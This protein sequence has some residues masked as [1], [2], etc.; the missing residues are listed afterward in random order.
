M[1]TLRHAQARC[2][3]KKLLPHQGR[4]QAFNIRK[5]RNPVHH[6]GRAP[7]ARVTAHHL[8]YIIEKPDRFTFKINT[9][10][11]PP[12]VDQKP[13]LWAH[14]MKNRT[15]IFRQNSKKMFTGRPLTLPHSRHNRP[16]Y[17]VNTAK[18]KKPGTVK[19]VITASGHE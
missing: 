4:N 18:A 15:T 6:N 1:L 9:F 5:K 14:I 3:H 17:T 16:V 7:H 13:E 8:L 10:V 2:P 11:I 12:K 19:I